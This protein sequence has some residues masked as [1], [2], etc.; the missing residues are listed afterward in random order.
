MGKAKALGLPDLN[1]PSWQAHL[2]PRPSCPANTGPGK[3][4]GY[5]LAVRRRSSETWPTGLPLAEQDN[6]AGLTQ[7]MCLLHATQTLRAEEEQ[8]SAACRLL[9][10]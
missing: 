5:C 6:H 3:C 2:P 9:Y 1:L 7:I 4:T 10:R 8:A